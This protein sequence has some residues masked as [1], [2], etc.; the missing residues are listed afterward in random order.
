MSKT[1]PSKR[2][3]HQAAAFTSLSAKFAPLAE[4]VDPGCRQTRSCIQPAIKWSAIWQLW[5]RSWWMCRSTS[6][7]MMCARLSSARRPR[8][9]CC[10]Q[11][12]SMLVSLLWCSSVSFYIEYVFNLQLKSGYNIT[13]VFGPGLWASDVNGITGWTLL[14]CS[15]L[16]HIRTWFAPSF[17]C[18]L[19]GSL[20]QYTAWF[21]PIAF[22]LWDAPESVFH[23]LNSLSDCTSF[24]FYLLSVA[25]A[26]AVTW[27]QL[28]CV[29][30]FWRLQSV[31]D[32]CQSTR[33]EDWC[34]FQC[35]LGYHSVLGPRPPCQG[36]WRWLLW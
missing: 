22:R 14:L 18:L 28:K 34:S 29:V 36:S 1:M 10:A 8:L 21:C 19:Q 32:T 25:R 27:C 24:Y 6:A 30:V 9:M 11:L 12:W 13:G 16:H 20:T 3:R 26:C 35:C 17:R 5:V 23:L 7:C 2:A 33:C 31:I 15:R 4:S